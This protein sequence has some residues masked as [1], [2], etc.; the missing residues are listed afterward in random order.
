MSSFQQS[1]GRQFIFGMDYLSTYLYLCILYMYV[2]L[3]KMHAVTE[4]IITLLI[5][6]WNCLELPGR[7]QWCMLG[8]YFAFGC[9]SDKSLI[10][11]SFSTSHSRQTTSCCC[12]LYNLMFRVSL[13]HDHW[14]SGEA[15]LKK[16][17]K[18]GGGWVSKIVVIRVSLYWQVAS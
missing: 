9:K 8:L 13:F 17:R 4:S 3:I 11:C 14:L 7:A 15:L 10:L 12:A 6:D 1:R 16:D 5:F 18:C 2:C